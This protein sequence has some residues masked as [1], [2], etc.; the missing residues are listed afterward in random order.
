MRLLPLALAALGAAL[1]VVVVTPTSRADAAEV[2]SETQ[3]QMQA[4]TAE[5]LR[6]E[7]AARLRGWVASSGTMGAE[8]AKPKKT[9]VVSDVVQTLFVASEPQVK[10]YLCPDPLDEKCAVRFRRLPASSQQQQQD[11]PDASSPT[12]KFAIIS[13]GKKP[14]ELISSID[15]NGKP[16][17]TWVPKVNQAPWAPTHANNTWIV[18]RVS[19]WVD[20]AVVGLNVGGHNYVLAVDDVSGDNTNRDL[21]LAPFYGVNFADDNMMATAVWVVDRTL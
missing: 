8:A 4:Q 16:Q 17:A 12:P 10:Y 13:S 1:M 15:E 18:T 2:E 19:E 21:V 14:Q 5:T 20:Y 7:V 6:S 3:T 11:A 9:A